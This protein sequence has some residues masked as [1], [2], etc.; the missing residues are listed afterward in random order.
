[1]KHEIEKSSDMRNGGIQFLVEWT[2]N[3]QAHLP[4]RLFG[5]S[6]VNRRLIILCTHTQYSPGETILSPGSE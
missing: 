3:N 2:Q 4:E 5:A 6:S 1:M